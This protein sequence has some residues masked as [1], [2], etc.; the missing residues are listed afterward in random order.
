MKFFD[1]EKAVSEIVGAMM[2]LL[3]V[4]LYIG[5]LQAYEVPKWNKELERQNYDMVSAE[6]ID[7]KSDLEDVS[8]RFIPKT[9]ALHMGVKYPERFM[10]RNPGPAYGTLST[11]P[12]N[13]TINITLSDPSGVNIT[14]NETKFISSG[15]E[16]KLNGLSNFP[17]L[18]YEHGLIIKDF[19]GVGL[20]D[21]SQSILIKGR[22]DFFIPIMNVSSISLSSVETESL[23]LNPYEMLI[24]NTTN[25]TTGVEFNIKRINITMETK[26]NKTWNEIFN[27]T[28]V[29]VEGN[30]INISIFVP[31]SSSKKYFVYPNTKV[32]FTGE[33]IYTGLLKYSSQNIGDT[34]IINQYEDGGGS[35]PFTNI[36]PS[37]LNYPNIAG[38]ILTKNSTTS[39]WDLS[40]T[41]NNASATEIY[42]DLTA[43]TDNIWMYDV[44]PTN[45]NSNTHSA[46]WYNLTIPNNQQHET[47]VATL[48]AKN[49]TMQ[50]YTQAIFYKSGG[51]WI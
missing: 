38:I 24:F 20:T 16:Y 50:Y 36:K 33:T 21:T 5:T 43:I 25:R 22:N 8:S 45:Y 42:A 6:F 39:K 3:I 44:N 18:V 32:I 23:N 14:Y 19:G 51:G 1:D 35:L 26:Y 13:I 4:V 34:Y 15:I 40:A 9:S 29:H 46:S 12:L 48:W 17:K 47:I 30:K 11:Y 31:P 27:D 7:M 2:I 49:G 28:R 37:M 10:L 41:V